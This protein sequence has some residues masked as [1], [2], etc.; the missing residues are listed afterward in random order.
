MVILSF[1]LVC[2][3]LTASVRLSDCPI[4]LARRHFVRLSID[5][6]ADNNVSRG[7]PGRPTNFLWP[8]RHGVT[9]LL[10]KCQIVFRAVPSSVE[11]VVAL[12]FFSHFFLPLFYSTSYHVAGLPFAFGL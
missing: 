7:H 10:A 11:S 9:M 3:A 12:L 5:G 6:V 2:W 8:A 4:A 1:C